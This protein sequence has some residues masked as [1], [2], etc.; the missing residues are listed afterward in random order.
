MTLFRITHNTRPLQVTND[1]MGAQR[2]LGQAQRELATG[3]R[4]NSPSD[5]P[6]S[7]VGALSTRSEISRNRQ[8]ERNAAAASGFTTASDEAMQ[9]VWSRANR[10]RELLISA[11]SSSNGDA[12]AQAAISG[13]LTQLREELLGLSNTAHMGRSVFG[14]TAGGPAYD[15]AT[16]AYLGDAGVFQLTVASNNTVRVNVTGT[17][18]FGT[19]NGGAPLSGDLFQIVAEGATEV[20]AGND[21]GIVAVLNALEVAVN[22][23]ED[24]QV[25]LGGWAR[26]INDL[27]DGRDSVHLDLTERLSLLEDADLAEVSVRARSTEIAYEAALRTANMVLGP[28]LADFLR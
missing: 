23:L 12:N 17:M 28:S 9:S 11:R 24:A 8:Y 14:G 6:L 5:D 1:L 27:Q 20:A 7:A 18:A 10:V 19:F 4:L 16:G 3:R 22:R 2:R 21:A 26:R 13:E 15:T 25:E